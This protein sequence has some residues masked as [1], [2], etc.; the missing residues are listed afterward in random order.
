MMVS[1]GA[2]E[3]LNTVPLFTLPPCNAVPY[4]VLPYK[5]NPA[6]GLAPSLLALLLSSAVKLC[7]FV[8]AVP[9]VLTPNTVPLPELPPYY[10]VPYRVLPDTINPAYGVAP[11]LLIKKG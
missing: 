10:A 11:S 7:R 5:I 6:Y 8:R 2:N 1:C 4:R 9:S 3:R